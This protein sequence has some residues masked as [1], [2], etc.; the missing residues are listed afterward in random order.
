MSCTQTMSRRPCGQCAGAD[1]ERRTQGRPHWLASLGG[2]PKEAL[3]TLS[4]YCPRAAMRAVLFRVA[5]TECAAGS[6]YNL[7]DQ[8]DLTQGKL[9]PWI[10]SLFK[11][12]TSFLGSLVSNLARLNLS[13]VA[14][15]ANDKHVPAFTQICHKQKILNTPITPYID[16]E[17]LRDNHLAIDGT[18]IAKDT[19]FKYTKQISI[20]LLKE[21]IDSFIQQGVFPPLP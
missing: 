19:S 8:V 9:N 11:I 3:L 18:N 20:E 21:Q 16:Q 13:G 5:A 1:G 15:E 14:S 6:I 7:A 4:A 12:E 17:L 2:R 10:S